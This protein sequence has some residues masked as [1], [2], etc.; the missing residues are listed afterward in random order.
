MVI[1]AGPAG[2]VIARLLASKGLRVAL[3]DA[4]STSA[5]KPGEVLTPNAIPALAVTG[6]LDVL[7]NRQDLAIELVGIRRIWERPRLTCESFLTQPGG[8]AWTIDRPAFEE[9]LKREAASAGVRLLMEH[10]LGAVERRKGIW[11]VEV[12][13]RGGSHSLRAAFLVDA[14]GRNATLARRVG[15]TRRR[16]YLLL[17]VHAQTKGAVEGWGESGSL[18][19]EAAAYGWWYAVE[20]PR[21]VFTCTL[22]CDAPALLHADRVRSALRGAFRETVLLP[23]GSDAVIREGRII[24]TDASPTCLDR[25]VGDGWLAVGDAAA[26]FDPVTSQGIANAIASTVSGANAIVCWLGGDRSAVEAHEEHTIATW[27]QS[28]WLSRAVYGSA[29][30]FFP[31]PFWNDR[32]T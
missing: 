17:A 3:L 10:R 1:G 14:S 30:R 23:A 6:L 9:T 28:L 8:R 29:A 27:K 20:G 18:L 24:R 26:S 5:P 4:R 11:S 25:V 15:A 13:G 32:A 22:L 2:A 16:A 21:S 19:I 12:L 7:E 31:T